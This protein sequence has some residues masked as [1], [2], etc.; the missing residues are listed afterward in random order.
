MCIGFCC[1]CKEGRRKKRRL[2]RK[3]GGDHYAYIGIPRHWPYCMCNTFVHKRC[4]NCN[5]SEKYHP[6][7]EDSGKIEKHNK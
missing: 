3:V 4:F 6:Y 1:I 2:E 5:L 7:D